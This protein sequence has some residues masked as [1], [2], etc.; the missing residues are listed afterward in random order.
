VLLKTLASIRKARV[1]DGW[2]ILVKISPSLRRGIQAFAE[3]KELRDEVCEMVRT[4]K[5]DLFAD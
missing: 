5:L 2:S 4:Y 1:D 3:N